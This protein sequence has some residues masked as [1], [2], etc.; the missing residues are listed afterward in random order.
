MTRFTL[1]KTHE[2]AS[3]WDDMKP[4]HHKKDHHPSRVGAHGGHHGGSNGSSHTGG[5]FNGNEAG[6]G[7]K[8]SK[9]KEVQ[10]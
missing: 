2:E 1:R 8:A 7:F 3:G 4:T 9:S 5:N 10:L 6:G